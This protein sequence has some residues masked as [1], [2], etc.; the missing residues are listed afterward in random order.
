MQSRFCDRRCIKAALKSETRLNW[1]VVECADDEVLTVMPLRTVRQVFIFVRQPLYN[2]RPRNVRAKLW[3]S[4]SQNAE[5]CDLRDQ[6]A[7]TESIGPP[8]RISIGSF[9]H[10][11]S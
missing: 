8:I 11:Y 4:R 6:S 2:F 5:A 7:K 9:F 1:R 10:S 3:A